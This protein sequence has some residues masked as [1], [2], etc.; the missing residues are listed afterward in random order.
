MADLF[1]HDR[2]MSLHHRAYEFIVEGEDFEEFCKHL[3]IL[4]KRD[5]DKELE[6]EFTCQQIWDTAMLAY[7]SGMSKHQAFPLSNQIHE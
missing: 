2:A 3:K 7:K 5:N 6:Q 1:L 4:A